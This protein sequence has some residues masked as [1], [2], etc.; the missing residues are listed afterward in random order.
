MKVILDKIGA[1]LSYVTSLPSESLTEAE[2]CP[3]IFA[4]PARS[5]TSKV[6]G[7]T[8]TF[9]AFPAVC[10]AVHLAFEKP[11]MADTVGLVFCMIVTV[12]DWT[13]SFAI[14]V[15]VISSAGTAY[16]ASIL[17]SVAISTV[18]MVGPVLSMVTT[19]PL[20][21]AETM[22]PPLPLLPVFPAKSLK[23]IEKETS[24]SVSPPITVLVAF[25]ALV[26]FAATVT[27]SDELF[28]VITGTLMFSDDSKVSSISSPSLA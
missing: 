3:S 1:V 21:V 10:T 9:S 5:K 23:L 18:E 15:M 17:L 20:V 16:C 25:Q 12:G 27:P 2:I 13:G 24:S 22:A 19:D 26:P 28:M 6:K 8:P 14:I 11:S 7:T 4:F